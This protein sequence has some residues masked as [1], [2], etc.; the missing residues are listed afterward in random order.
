MTL[1]LAA[2]G[3]HLRGETEVGFQKLFVSQVK[4]SQVYAEIRKT[5]STGQAHLAATAPEAEAELRILEEKRD[6]TVHSLTGSGIVYDYELK[7][8][9]HY[10]LTMPGREDPLIAPTE[11]AARRLITFSASAPTAKEAEEQLL[12]KDMQQD[13]ARRILRHVAVMK[14]EVS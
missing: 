5:L 2:C 7:L 13:L 12:Y 6:K 3:F 1:A 11:V 10:Q 14:R 9:V 4:P 8:T